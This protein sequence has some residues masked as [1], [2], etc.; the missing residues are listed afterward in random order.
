MYKLLFLSIAAGLGFLV[1]KNMPKNE[2][3]ELENNIPKQEQASVA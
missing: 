3:K 2:T 1:G